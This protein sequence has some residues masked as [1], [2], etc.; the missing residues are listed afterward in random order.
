[1]KKVF[2]GRNDAKPKLVSADN[3]VWLGST[4]SLIKSSGISDVG[5]SSPKF[6]A[7]CYYLNRNPIFY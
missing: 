1:M 5:F 6:S 4:F 7:Q 3:G 2:L